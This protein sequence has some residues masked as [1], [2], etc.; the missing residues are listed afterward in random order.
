MDS[1]VRHLHFACVIHC[2]DTISIT[3]SFLDDQGFPFLPLCLKQVIFSKDQDLIPA[4]LRVLE[5][6]NITNQMEL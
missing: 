2:P 5:M 1:Q 3:L 6:G 4:E